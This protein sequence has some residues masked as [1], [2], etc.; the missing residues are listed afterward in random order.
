M[1]IKAL[2]IPLVFALR[3]RASLNRVQSESVH[4]LDHVFVIVR[5]TTVLTRFSIIPTPHS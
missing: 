1:K 5:R 2:I 3:V 4:P